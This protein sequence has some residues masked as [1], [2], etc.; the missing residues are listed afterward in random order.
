[1]VGQEMTWAE[2]NQLV[3]EIWRDKEGEYM[4]WWNYMKRLT[5]WGQLEFRYAM[6]G[7]KITR[8][9]YGRYLVE[10]I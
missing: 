6:V 9:E 7:F 10:M 4:R 1:M 2:V 3:G 5:A 8:I